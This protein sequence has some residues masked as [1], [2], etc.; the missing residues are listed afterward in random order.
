MIHYLVQGLP[1][2]DPHYAQL[3]RQYGAQEV[4][5]ALQ[6]YSKTAQ[7]HDTLL[8]EPYSYRKYRQA[9][10]VFGGQRRYLPAAEYFDLQME[11]MKLFFP[12]A[13]LSDPSFQPPSLRESELYDLLLA[14]GD[15][16]R[17][18]TPPS[19]PPRPVEYPAPRLAYSAELQPLFEIGPFPPL[20]RLPGW[21]AR[22]PNGIISL[23]KSSI[24]STPPTCCMAGPAM[25]APGR[26]C[27]P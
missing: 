11:F 3:A 20:R 4:A 8:D 6:N 9:F 24:S 14:E 21:P 23:L 22:P 19:I 7:E 25:Q 12:R 10:A 26:P 17:D 15:S 5:A 2:D 18:I 27:M 13:M 16:W 1:S